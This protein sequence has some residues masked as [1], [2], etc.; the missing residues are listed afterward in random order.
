[1]RSI[2]LLISILA[3]GY[4]IDGPLKSIHHN[5]QE[6]INSFLCN[7][8]KAKEI[9]CTSRLTLQHTIKQVSFSEIIVLR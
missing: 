8:H 7:T 3:A 1:M 6:M 2:K 9:A 5:L 4:V